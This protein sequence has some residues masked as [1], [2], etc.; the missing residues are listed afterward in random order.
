MSD[1]GT[2]VAFVCTPLGNRLC[3]PCTVDAQCAGGFCLEDSAGD[4][5]CSRPC[6]DNDTCPEGFGCQEVTSEAAFPYVPGYLT[7]R[8]APA[9]E[10]AF[11]RL[12]RRP[13]LLLVDGHGWAHP[14]RFGIAC[15]LGLWLDLPTVGCAKSRLC[16][17]YAEPGPERGARS[18]LV[19]RGEVVGAVVRTRPRVKPLFVSPGHRCDLEGAVALVLATSAKYRLPIPARL[20]H[21]YVNDIRRAANAGRPIPD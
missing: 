21:A 14:R 3:Q 15:H 11:S 5:A 7:F 19:D 10:A 16:G 2:D 17:T 12:A 18:P 6:G 9:V 8:E 20:A 13:D 1:R 4:H